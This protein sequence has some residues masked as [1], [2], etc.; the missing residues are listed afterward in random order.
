MPRAQP[1]SSQQGVVVI[2]AATISIA[3]FFHLVLLR[4]SLQPFT[5]ILSLRSSCSSSSYLGALATDLRQR[6]LPASKI[7]MA[8]I[9]ACDQQERWSLIAGRLPGRTDNEIKNHWNTHLSRRSMSIDAL[10]LKLNTRSVSSPRGI[11]PLDRIDSRRSEFYYDWE[12]LLMARPHQMNEDLDYEFGRWMG[13][14][15]NLF[16]WEPAA[17]E[18]GEG[19]DGEVLKIVEE[20]NPT[21]PDHNPTRSSHVVP[22]GRGEGCDDDQSLAQ[23][24]HVTLH[25]HGEGCDDDQSSTQPGCVTHDYGEGCDDH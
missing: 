19:K 22:H 13:E 4:Q 23:P 21:W 16:G 17:Y 12:Q 10:N 2:G 18:H 7:P 20:E 5:V 6:V 25:G 11:I 3:S 15:N 9:S 8:A 1:Q 14:E 24:G